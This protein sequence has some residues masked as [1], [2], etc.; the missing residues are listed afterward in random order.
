MGQRAVEQTLGRLLTDEEFRGD[1]ER[2]PART[3][4]AAGFELTPVELAALAAVPSR[5]VAR[6]SA[7]LD[8]RI[9][10]LRC[11]RPPAGV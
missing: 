3:A 4:T 5:A 11:P 10:R 7:Q 9:R 8:E 1:F 2:D 6:W